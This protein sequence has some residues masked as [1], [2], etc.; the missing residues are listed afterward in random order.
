M[1]DGA[2]RFDQRGKRG[3]VRAQQLEV[4][5]VHCASAATYCDERRRS[6]GVS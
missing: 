4:L 3:R 2:A 6:A 5:T 1:C